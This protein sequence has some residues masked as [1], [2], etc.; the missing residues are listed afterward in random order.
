M[1]RLLALALCLF[2]AACTRHGPCSGPG[3][4]YHDDVCDPGRGDVCGVDGA[5]PG[6]GGDAGPLSDGGDGGALSDGGDAGT[7]S[8]GGVDAGDAGLATITEEF[9]DDSALARGE[10]TATIDPANGGALVAF[11]YT[12]SDD[13]RNDYAP[14]ASVTFDGGALLKLGSLH[15]APNIRLVAQGGPLEIR[16]CGAVTIDQSAYLA[17]DGE[18][19]VTAGG[20]MNVAGTVAA[21]SLFVTLADAGTSFT[22][23]GD[24]AAMYS[25]SNLA[26]PGGPLRLLVNGNVSLGG[27][28]QLYAEGAPGTSVPPL[29]IAA[30]GNFSLADSARLYTNDGNGVPGGAPSIDVHA[31]GDLILGG[32][33]QVNL[34]P[35]RT[36]VAP[37]HLALAAGGSLFVKGSGVNVAIDRAPSSISLGARADINLDGGSIYLYDNETDAGPGSRIDFQS[38]GAFSCAGNASITAGDSDTVPPYGR[39]P[40]DWGSSLSIAARSVA[41]TSC[42]LATSGAGPLGNSGSVSITAGDGGVAV[43]A[44]SRWSLGTNTCSAGESIAVRSAGDLTVAAGAALAAGSSVGLLDGGCAPAAG[45]GVSLTAAGTAVA[46]GAI[47]GQGSP[48]GGVLVASGVA[49]DAGVPQVALTFPFVGTSRVYDLGAAARVLAV[50]VLERPRPPEGGVLVELSMSDSAVAGFSGWTTDFGALGAHRYLRWRATVDAYFLQTA[51]LDR[52]EID[53]SR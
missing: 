6:D 37:R 22:L 3:C 2:P 43:G 16:T 47:G 19:R 27:R 33:G 48:D 50:R 9:Y 26:G 10:S 35:G 44:G 7:P 29:L 20:N 4:D 21:G 17:G 14:D 8:D 11:V 40:S 32:F 46:G 23:N 30:A 41:L 51:A 5:T 36:F 18:L 52:L 49:F 34:A 25:P 53:Y 38:G 15:L 12:A 39:L 42:S 45:G 28:A 24:S 1:K 13:C 31:L